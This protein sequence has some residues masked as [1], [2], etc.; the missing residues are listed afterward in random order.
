MLQQKPKIV[1]QR[2]IIVVKDNSSLF[3][4]V[5]KAMAFAKAALSLYGTYLITKSII[6]NVKKHT[7]VNVTVGEDTK[8]T[9]GE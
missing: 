7:V 6:K 5:M 1:V 2:K 4:E 8:E 3:D 9:E